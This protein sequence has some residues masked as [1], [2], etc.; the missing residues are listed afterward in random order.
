VR[1]YGY[2]YGSLRENHSTSA[3]ACKAAAR[4]EDG[5]GCDADEKMMV[6]ADW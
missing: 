2:G 1:G 6:D 4:K 5:K 3:S